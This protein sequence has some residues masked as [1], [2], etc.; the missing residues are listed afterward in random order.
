MAGTSVAVEQAKLLNEI[1]FPEFTAKLINDV[2]DA[3]V[4]ANLRQTESYIELLQAVS[5]TLTTYLNDTKDDI[6]GEDILQFL[7]DVFPDPADAANPTLIKE[8]TVLTSAQATTLN[9]ALALPSSAGVAA[10]NQVVP[11]AGGTLDANAV[12]SITSAVALRLASNKYDILKEMVKQGILRLVV[13]SGLVETRLTFTT[14]GSSFYEK[15]ETGYRS[16]NFNFAANAQTG[17]RLA[18]WVKAAASTSYTSVNVRTT[19]ETQ[20]D[21]SGSSVQ[22]FGRVQI[23]FKTDYLPLNK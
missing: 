22:I 8:N 6:T 11:A 10:N 23:N 12:Q 3:L 20:R 14:Y 5:K 16:T 13:D 21:V 19:N 18:K 9:D 2:F 7:V 1:G 4:S 17:K 15:H